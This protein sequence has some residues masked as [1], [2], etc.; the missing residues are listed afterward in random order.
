M[1]PIS[2]YAYYFSTS[3]DY[4]NNTHFSGEIAYFWWG[5]MVGGKPPTNGGLIGHIA[6]G[7]NTLI[8]WR[9]AH[10]ETLKASAHAT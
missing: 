2:L 9:M 5:V 3:T 8:Q 10:K 4:L 1:F 7:G 6:Q